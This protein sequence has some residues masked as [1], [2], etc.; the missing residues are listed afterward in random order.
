MSVS[1]ARATAQHP[2]PDL[3]LPHSWFSADRLLD[4][5]IHLPFHH[6]LPLHLYLSLLP[7]PCILKR[8]GFSFSFSEITM[9][10]VLRISS[11]IPGLRFFQQE[12]GK[13]GRNSTGGGRITESQCRRPRSKSQLTP[14]CALWGRLFHLF[15][16][17]FRYLGDAETRLVSLYGISQG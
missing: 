12:V 7:S 6:I 2:Q 4:T 3:S 15:R 9:P 13:K 10:A 16:S 17:Q 14:A 1:L 11:P 8:G 5:L